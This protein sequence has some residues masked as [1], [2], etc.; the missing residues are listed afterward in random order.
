VG[1]A[2]EDGA[3][4]DEAAED[5]REEARRWCHSVLILAAEGSVLSVRKLEVSD[6]LNR[7][8]GIRQLRCAPSA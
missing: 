8:F 3:G 5:E 4:G 2:A 7:S 6:N 1:G